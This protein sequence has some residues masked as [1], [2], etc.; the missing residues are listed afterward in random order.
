MRLKRYAWVVIAVLLTAGTLA[1]CGCSE[2]TVPPISTG[3]PKPAPTTPSGSTSP[4]TV[5]TNVTKVTM[6]GQAF[7][8]AEVTIKVGEA[9]SWMNDDSVAHTITG[10]DF[11]S[12]EIQP[13]MEFIR[14]FTKPG[15]YD[16]HCTIHPTMTGKTIVQ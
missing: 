10:A 8:P 1:G 4:G 15:T 9:V 16:Y 7:S 3:P 13:G 12:G 14:T 6:K 2:P 5:Q 11:D